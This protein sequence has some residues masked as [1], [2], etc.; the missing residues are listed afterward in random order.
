MTNPRDEDPVAIVPIEDSI[1]LHGFRPEDVS[2]VVEEYLHA[3]AE[4][5]FVEVRLIHGRGKGVQRANVQRVLA[6][7]PLVVEFRDAPAARGGWGATLVWLEPVNSPVDDRRADPRL[8][9]LDARAALCHHSSRALRSMEPRCSPTVALLLLCASCGRSA[10]VAGY[11]TE[12]AGDGSV[13][14]E[15]WEEMLEP[16]T[17]EHAVENDSCTPEPIPQEY[18]IHPRVACRPGPDYDSETNPVRHCAIDPFCAR[19]EECTEQPF[20]VCRGQT[21]ASCVYPDADFDRSCESDADCAPGECDIAR[22][23]ADIECYPTGEC[24]EPANHCRPPAE[25]C[26]SDADCTALPEGTCQR[27][28]FQTTCYYHACLEASDCA[29]GRACICSGLL[30]RN[31]CVAGDCIADEDCDAGLECRAE[32]DCHEHPVG[33]HCSSEA[34]SCRSNADCTY[35]ET[36]SFAEGSWRCIVRECHTSTEP[37]HVVSAFARLLGRRH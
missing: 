10:D 5:G 36:C 18:R 6:R 29:T 37:R 21:T 19:H 4:R 25:A 30:A 33:V 9:P 12:D 11:V 22:D 28:I 16:L 14:R 3:A 17:G 2:S 20:G 32:R 31:V 15:Q 34:D 23:Y 13:T 1:D 27:R 24:V 35:P 7:H 8:E 26:A